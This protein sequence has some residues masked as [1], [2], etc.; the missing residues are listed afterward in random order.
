MIFI[1]FVN[2][3]NIKLISLANSSIHL[4]SVFWVTTTFQYFSK[5]YQNDYYFKQWQQRQKKHTSSTLASSRRTV[6][7]PETQKR[8][9]VT[10]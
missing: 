4:E 5:G 6:S 10:I 1:F 8:G 2:L 3:D 9:L 7:D